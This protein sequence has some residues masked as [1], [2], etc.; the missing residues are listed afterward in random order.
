MPPMV[1]GIKMGSEFKRN[2]A[3]DQ[4]QNYTISDLI[5]KLK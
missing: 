1:T 3:N 4:L 5:N 2:I